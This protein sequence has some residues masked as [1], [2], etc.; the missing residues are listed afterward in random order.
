MSAKVT[1]AANQPNQPTHA[2]PPGVTAHMREMT[3][4]TELSFD[5]ARGRLLKLSTETS[6]SISMSLP[7]STGAARSTEMVIKG[8]MTLEVLDRR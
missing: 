7:L 5:I 2:E 8:T 1:S 3:G 6:Q 4:L